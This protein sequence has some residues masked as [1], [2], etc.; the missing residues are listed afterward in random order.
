MALKGKKLICSVVFDEMNIRKHIQWSNAKKKFIGYSTI[1]NDETVD[2]SVNENEA[3][4]DSR[5]KKLNAA[6]QALVFL[7]RAVND[8]FE[9][10]IAYYFINSMDGKTKKSLLERLIEEL[11]D[12]NVIVSN[13][14]FDGYQANKTMCKLFG[15][16]LNVYSPFF[17]PHI[18]VRNQ[19]V[20]IFCDAC[21]MLKLIRNRLG[22]K[23]VLFDEEDNEIRWQYFIDLVHMRSRGLCT[24]KMTLSHID[25][26]RNKMKVDL[27]AE[28]LSESTAASIQHLMDTGVQEFKGAEATIKFIR[29]FNQL[30]DI[31]NSKHEQNKNRF[32]QALSQNNAA[33]I[34]KFFEQTIQYIKSL[35]VKTAKGKIVRVCR[36][37]I[38][39]GFRGFVINM[40][41]LKLLFQ[42]LVE[43][44]HI[45]IS[46]KTYN[47]QQDPI[48]IL[49]G[50]VRSLNGFNDN[51]TCE[52]FAAA[53][54]KLL[55]YNTIMFSNF[56]NCKLADDCEFNPYSNI[57]SVTSKR[58]VTPKFDDTLVE[59]VTDERIIQ[60]YEKL[61]K[62]DASDDEKLEELNDR[63]IAHIAYG[64]ESSI[65]LTK[66]FSCAPCKEIFKENGGDDVISG[67]KSAI[68]PCS[69]TF[70]ICKQADRFLKIELMKDGLNFDIIYHEIL[71]NLDFDALY[72]KTDFSVHLEHKV[73]LIR[74]IMDEFIRIKCTQIAKTESTKEHEKS[75][76]VKL[77]KLLHFLG[78]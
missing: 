35:K 26:E 70:S 41:S 51:P 2:D 55:A 77:H 50:K 19:S 6:N 76:R 23:R 32:K 45:V 56:S 40:V 20:Q 52:Q 58:K 13:I 61:N 7:V 44:R 10:P 22:A 15:A 24:H 9:L 30:F 36:S 53:I 33:E 16:E 63:T 43:E 3:A 42:E 39:T 37:V 64:I 46:L 4:D 73:F 75:L 38:N 68:K 11:M 67:V 69:S 17:Q 27:A 62:I 18:R 74:Y 65:Q 47:F 14:T 59:N 21:H 34:F 60:F 66:Q 54:R 1:R 49:F 31:F 57:L 29:T 5:E 78:Q 25:F 28:T 72:V 8:N 71:Q 12:C 48:E